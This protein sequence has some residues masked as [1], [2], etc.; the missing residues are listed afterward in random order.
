M[1]HP[2]AVHEGLQWLPESVRLRPQDKH[3]YTYL[4]WRGRCF[5]KR[6]QRYA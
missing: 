3:L 2:P 4:E 1:S 6:A 5:A